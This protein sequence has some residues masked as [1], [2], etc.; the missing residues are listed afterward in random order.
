MFPL[1]P[2]SAEPPETGSLGHGQPADF[3]V[4]V[5]GNSVDYKTEVK[6]MMD[7]RDVTN[8]LKAAGFSSKQIASFPF[9]KTLITDGHELKIAKPQI[10]YLIKQGLIDK[11]EWAKWDIY[12]TYI[13]TQRF[14][15]K[16]VVHVEHAYRPFIAAGTASGYSRGHEG[17][18]AP[19]IGWNKSISGF[20]LNEQQ[21]QQLDT[22]FA[23]KGQLDAYGEIPSTIVGYIL[24]TANS[25]KDGIRNFKLR[26]HAGSKDEIVSLCFPAKINRMSEQL[27]EAEV[28]DFRPKAELSVYFGNCRKCGDRKFRYGDYGVAPSFK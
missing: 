6:A 7:G 11:E 15:A 10:D 23:D 5:D 17:K 4:V 12:V 16:A 19:K 2:Y 3:M 9:D 14:P 1:P 13:W 20:C 25:W 18:E 27:Y 28:K 26:V 8:I 22:I 21:L 24:T